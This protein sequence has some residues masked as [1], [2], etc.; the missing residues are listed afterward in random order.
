MQLLR[1]EVGL[2][3]DPTAVSGHVSRVIP[4]T[5][6]V[7]VGQACAMDVLCSIRQRWPTSYRSATDRYVD[8][9]VRIGMTVGTYIAPSFGAATISCLSVAYGALT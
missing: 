8:C 1:L 4:R 3:P 2:L 5:S 7:N 6:L 9:M